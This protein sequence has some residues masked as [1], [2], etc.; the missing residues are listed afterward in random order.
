[1]KIAV[2]GCGAMGS[3]YAG[4]LASAGNAVCVVDRWQA[5]VDAI[6]AH[7]LR[8]DPEHGFDAFEVFETLEALEGEGQLLLG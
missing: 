7:G 2:V 1:M 8:V 4:L 5:H 3:I 6:N